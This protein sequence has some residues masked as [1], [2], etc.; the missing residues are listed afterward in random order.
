MAPASHIAVHQRAWTSCVGQATVTGLAHSASPRVSERARKKRVLPTW[1]KACGL[2]PPN[3]ERSATNPVPP[4]S[5]LKSS[6]PTPVS[7]SGEEF[8]SPGARDDLE[9]SV[10]LSSRSSVPLSAPPRLMDF[11]E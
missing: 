3:G 2:E 1:V 7:K 6:V 11:P 9:S 10:L 5:A 8:S 4:T